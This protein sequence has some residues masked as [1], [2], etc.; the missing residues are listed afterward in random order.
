MK[1]K[2]LAAALL[3]TTANFGY[4]ADAVVE[5]VVVV[6]SAYNW[7]G[8]YVGGTIGYGWA[9]T[10]VTELDDY[11]FSDFGDT[12]FDFDSD[13]I[14]GGVF[15]GAN[16]QSGSFDYGV[17]ADFSAT[18]INN[19]VENTMNPGT[20]ESFSNT[21]DWFGTIRGRLGYAMD[22]TLLYATGGVAFAEI[23]SSYNDP[24]DSTFAVASG[25]AWGWT[26]GAGAE[27]AVTDNWTLRGEYLY[28]DL[29]DRQGSF[30]DGGT[31]RYDFDNDMNVV[32]IGAAY[33][34]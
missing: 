29:E 33:K 25:T 18:D 10:N 5:E 30:Q 11:S 22:R 1:T 8:V 24:L 4:A 9:D 21:I 14:L 15:V 23:R 7:S 17:E 3:L 31:F 28:V 26:I 13:G 34:F 16:W 6:D 12:E 27:Y 19:T 2:I 32:R 20:G